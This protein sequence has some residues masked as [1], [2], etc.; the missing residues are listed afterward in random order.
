MENISEYDI[1]Q[2]KCLKSLEFFTRYFF[3]KKFNTKFIVAP[4]HALIIDTLEKIVRGELTR[5]IFNMPPRY[6]KTELI[7]KNFIAWCLTLNDSAKFIHLSYSDSLALDNSEE[8][9]DL[10]TADYYKDIFDVNIKQGSSAKN[11][12]YTENNG[13]VLAR[14]SSGQVT[15][16]GLVVLMKKMNRNF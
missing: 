12:W 6:G 16:F 3:K 2:V 14:S 8:I 10:I 11:K 4:H 9:K 15:G 5:V 7:V 13:G 1:I